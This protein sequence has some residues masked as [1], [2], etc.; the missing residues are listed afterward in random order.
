LFDGTYYN[1]GAFNSYYLP[2]QF[3]PSPLLAFAPSPS[4]QPVGWD[5]WTQELRLTSPDNPPYPLKWVA[6]LYVTQQHV[7]Y[8]QNEIDPEINSIFQKLYGVPIGSISAAEGGPANYNNFFN[9]IFSSA[10][11]ETDDQYA[12]FA[13][14]TYDIRPDL[15]LTAGLRYTL[16][17]EINVSN[18][19]L[20][21]FYDVGLAAEAK[22]TIK[23]YSATP[24]F[25]LAYDIND[26]S[27]IY[28]TEAKGFRLGGPSGQL[29]TGPGNVCSQDYANLGISGPPSSYSP[30][31]LWSYEA[32]IKTTALDHTL[33]VNAAGYYINWTN[34][35]QSVNLPICGFG[36]TAN[37]GDAEVYGSELEVVYAPPMLKGLKLGVTGAFNHTSITK[38]TATFATVGEALEDV[39]ERTA[40]LSADYDFPLMG[41]WNGFVHGDYNFNGHSHGSFQTDLPNFENQAYGVVNAQF[42]VDDENWKVYLFAKN[43]LNDHTIY[44]QIEQATVVEGYTARPLTVGISARRDF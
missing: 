9:P 11:K 21:S 42:G 10:S 41:G 31:S 23:N 29:P 12:A 3:T 35:Q 8:T 1:S 24:R 34:A 32:G 43:L 13:S 14:V 36:Y 17:H 5:T 15:H 37:A 28:T 2:A 7:G 26:T 20:T 6:G 39:P 38:T 25:S 33:S 40:T 44:Q 4:Y 16:S 27:S 30:D 22:S 19:L 18:N